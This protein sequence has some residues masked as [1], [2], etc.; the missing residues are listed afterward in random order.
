MEP[1]SPGSSKFKSH[2]PVF[3]VNSIGPVR[4]LDKVDDRQIDEYNQIIALAQKYCDDYSE[5]HQATPFY[6]V[7][8][9]EMNF[10]W[11]I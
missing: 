2:R 9:W 7:L 3:A 1:T 4:H 6:N 8:Q 10:D 5:P 11:I